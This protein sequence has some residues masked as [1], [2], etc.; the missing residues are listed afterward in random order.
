MLKPIL[1][2]LAGACATVLITTTSALAGSGVGAVFNL[3]QTNTVNQKS[4]LT[5]ATSDSELLVQNTGSGSALNLATGA[6]V[7]AFKVN[8]STKIGNLNADLLDGL[9]STALQKRVTGTCT[10][11]QAIRVVNAE[12]TV[13]C[14][15]VGIAGA[16]GLKGNSGSIPGTNFLGTTDNKALEL[17]V[18]GQRALRLEPNATSPNLI[19]GFSG[20]SVDPVLGAVIAGG[21][22]SARPNHVA[23]NFAVI[24]GG[25][26][27]T[28]GG[29]GSTVA[30]GWFN[31]ASGDDSTVAGGFD[32]TASGTGAF[33]GGEGARATNNY[34]F[35]WNGAPHHVFSTGPDSF[36]VGAD[37]GASFYS[38][39][40][41][42]GVATAGV[43]L[44][45]GNSSWS[46]V[47]D[48]ASKRN[49]EQVDRQGLLRR[50]ARIPIT[51]W[52]YKAQDPS[53]RH[54]GPMAQDVWSAFHLGE[55]HTRIDTI[56]AD[57][58]ALAA[59][60][61]LYR[62][63]QALQ[64]R[65]TTIQREDRSLRAQLGAQNARLTRLERAFSKL[66]R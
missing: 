15:P 43:Q 14:E 6:G 23:N 61:G 2:A 39:F 30:G 28:A 54:I 65:N 26:A 35:V 27:N 22:E 8:S 25:E 17:K 46:S 31:T 19:G 41:S 34:S 3:G 45:A 32:N 5:G 50:L 59:I 21:G 44:Y 48:R 16:W 29:F 20:N 9:D 7:P 66:S 10:A 63:N 55:T 52:S 33:A 12:G 53:I 51:R 60:Q 4:T 18:N 1:Y 42:N 58:I 24:S 40:N 36:T 11:G 37:G 62:Q 56:D 47:S 38:G 64:R 49:F 13:A 57:G